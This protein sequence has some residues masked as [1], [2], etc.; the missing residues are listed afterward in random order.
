MSIRRESSFILSNLQQ[1]EI[2]SI[3]LDTHEIIVAYEPVWAIGTGHADTPQDAK[4]IIEFIKN[5]L[6]Q[7]TQDNIPVLYGGSVSDK[8]V[9]SY[10][11]QDSVDGVL[12]G[13]SSTKFG[14]FKQIIHAVEQIV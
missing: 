9:V 3:N 1:S 2:D 6:K 14:T 13:S 7:Y 5:E 4:V 10:I 11:L 12:I 8:N